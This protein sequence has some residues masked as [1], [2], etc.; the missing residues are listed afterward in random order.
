MVLHKIFNLENVI[1]YFVH[2]YLLNNSN[3]FFFLK[4]NIY[5]FVTFLEILTI[6]NLIKHFNFFY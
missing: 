2:L 5:L 6:S 3:T 4:K 1:K